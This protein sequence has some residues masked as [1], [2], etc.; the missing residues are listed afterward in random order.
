M[1]SRDPMDERGRSVRA[2]IEAVCRTI[3]ERLAEEP[4]LDELAAS[5]D[6]S[7]FHFHR[8]FR[9][10][11]GE[12]VAGY[13]RRLRLERAA[14]R[15][16]H[17]EDDLLVVALDAGYGSH[18]AFTRAFRRQ[19]GVPPSEYRSRVK[20]E[21]DA[22]PE[23][24]EL[25]VRIERVEPQVVACA[26]HVGPYSDVGDAWK[27]LMKWGWRRSLFGRPTTFGLSHDDPDVTEPERLRYDACMV[28]APGTTTKG[29]VALRDLPGGSFAVTEH[30]GPYAAIGD[31]YASLFAH[32]VSRPIGG[33]RWTLGDPPAREVYLNDPR[34]TKPTDLR[35]EIW[36]PVHPEIA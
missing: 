20:G 26:R 23:G 4:T 27:A 15:I 1:A 16:E 3:E 2:R 34:R 6:L 10:L 31:T 8:L 19:F 36:M 14:Y 29:P 11:V 28:V 13:A 33:R 9:G 35:T 18:E 25:E 17:G 24:P 7:T 32:V 12:T 30:A 5:A 21:A 22:A